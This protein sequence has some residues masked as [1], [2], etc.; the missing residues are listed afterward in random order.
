MVQSWYQGG[1]SVFDW[2]DPTNAQ[3]IAFFDRGPLDPTQLTAAGHW[4]AYWYNGYIYGSEEYRGLDILELKP[5]AMLSQNEIDA[6]KSVRVAQLNPQGQEKIVWPASFA[7]VRSY[8]D[9]LARGD[10][11]A[12]AR[13]TAIS[14]ELA[15]AEGTSGTARRDALTRIAVALDADAQIARDGARVRMMATAVRDLAAVQR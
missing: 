2:S 1:I 9:Q 6:A 5:N 10:G 3:E 4:S 12:R 7:V 15:A 13:A 8:L 14:V 11:I